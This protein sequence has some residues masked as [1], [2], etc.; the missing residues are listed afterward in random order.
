MAYRVAFETLGCRLNQAETA[1]L[2]GGFLDRGFEI[3]EDSATADLCVINTC[4]LT[5]QAMSKCR[6]KIRSILRKNPDACI[7]AVGCYAE[8][9]TDVLSRM[10]GVDYVVGTADKLRLPE[11]VRSPGKQA[12]TVVVRTH[13]PPEPFEVPGVGYYPLRTRAN[14]KIQ[15]GCSFVCSFCIVPQSRGPARS[16]DFHDVLREARELVSLGF[17][18]IVLTGVNIGTY[19]DSGRGLADL[20]RALSE[21]DGL[22]RI[23][24]SSIEPTTIE[25]S[26]ID[27]MAQGGRLCPYLHIPI[28]S[29][30]D[31]V[32]RRM[33]RKYGVGECVSFIRRVVAR[34]PNVGLGTDIMVGFPG[35]SETAF[36]RSYEL[37]RELP[38]THIHVFSFSARRRTAA[39]HM[40]D[41]V[42]SRVIAERSA[43][44]HDLGERKKREYYSA[45]R[46]EALRV[47]F[48]GRESGGLF[49][50][51][52]DNYVK[53]G[54]DTPFDLS[55]RLA[56]VRA[57]GTIRRS[58]EAPLLATG[59]LLEMEG[60]R[61]VTS[62]EHLGGSER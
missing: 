11:I 29:G 15:E 8:T 4:A 26:L 13:M 9:D 55:N 36:G 53:V 19:C 16:R 22:E 49:T 32:L 12:R 24:L 31:Q 2:H 7:A 43:V 58:S 52:S 39:Y 47:L 59:S 50:G 33:R 62:Q 54:V 30:D 20:T 45:Q 57:A 44:M 5:S 28:Q 1:I 25:E 34:V 42:P 27:L 21:L 41:T 35:E 61:G 17:R 3:V 56:L 40:K 60:S 38:F 10:E 14:L 37:V 51:F 18:E 6:R 48:E 23:R 46:G